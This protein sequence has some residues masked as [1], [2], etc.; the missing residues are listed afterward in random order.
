MSEVIQ[1]L[2][3][4]LEIN[5]L[6]FTKKPILIGGMAMEYYG[7]RKA[8][9]DIDL[10]IHDEDYQQLAINNP[11]KRKDLWGDLGVVI[12][13]FEI[14][15]SIARFDYDFFSK[16]AIDEKVAFVVSLDRLLFMRVI[17]MDDQKYKNDLQLIKEYYYKNF[18]NQ[19]F[20]SNMEKNMLSYKKNNG[21]V[22]GGNYT[23]VINIEC[24]KR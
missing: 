10:V 12:D 11:D 18:V 20:Y 5:N 8:G 17:A 24:P 6:H 19:D 23:N 3:K 21:I 13:S 4:Q 15:R 7:M 9:W 16:D 2:I 14:W 22:L 1:K